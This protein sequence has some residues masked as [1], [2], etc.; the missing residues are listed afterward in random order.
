MAAQAMIEQSQ[1]DRYHRQGL[2]G[3]SGLGSAYEDN[4]LADRKAAEQQAREQYAKGVPCVSPAVRIE[5]P[6]ECVPPSFGGYYT[7][8]RPLLPTD[9]NDCEAYAR[10]LCE[11]GKSNRKVNSNTISECDTAT[12]TA[13]CRELAAQASQRVRSYGEQTIGDPVFDAARVARQAAE[14]APEQAGLI[15]RATTS[16]IAAYLRAERTAELVG[17]AVRFG[18]IIGAGVAAYLGWRTYRRVRQR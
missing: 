3:L 11:W 7:H 16:D 13:R 8:P 5:G 18:L 15:E 14:A 17:R 10:F 2:F 12:V 6:F 9:P 4:Y 1:R